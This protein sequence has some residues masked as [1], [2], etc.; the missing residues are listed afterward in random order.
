MS[1]SRFN[2]GLYRQAAGA[3][4]WGAFFAVAPLGM[5]L[6]GVLIWLPLLIWRER[7]RSR[8]YGFLPGAVARLVVVAA[9]LFVADAAPLKLEDRRVGPLVRSK[10]NLG[11]LADA[12]ILRAPIDARLESIPVVFPS[13]NPTRRDV[14]RAIEEQTGF[15]TSHYHC[16]SM[17]SVLFG[18]ASGPIRVAEYRDGTD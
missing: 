15:R 13:A 14:M 5:L 16:G 11:E 6:P 12:G 3:L 2:A 7:V 17:A 1:A 9:V 4:P 8:R 10:L 18:S